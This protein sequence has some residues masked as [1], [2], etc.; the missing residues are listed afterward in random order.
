MVRCVA[1]AVFWIAIVPQA[2]D[3]TI[4]AEH[5]GTAQDFTDAF[6]D[7]LVNRALNHWSY[8]HQ[9]V[10]DTTLNKASTDRLGSEMNLA[11]APS[12]ARSQPMVR[13]QAL[14]ST[15]ATKAFG[16]FP[17]TSRSTVPAGS[18]IPTARSL[19]RQ[20]HQTVHALPVAELEKP[21]QEQTPQI[22]RLDLSDKTKSALAKSFASLPVKYHKDIEGF[23]QVTSKAFQ[24]ALSSEEVAAIQSIFSESGPASIHITNLP[25]SAEGKVLI[26]TPNDLM[27]VMKPVHK[28]DATSEAN[29]VGAAGLLGASVFT[30]SNFYGDDFVRNFPRKQGT[31][32]GWH[33][34]GVTAPP[35]RPPTQFFRDEPLIPELVVIFCLRGNKQAYTRVV[36]FARLVAATDK[37]DV[38]LLRTKPLVF[39]DTLYNNTMEPMYVV[40]GPEKEPVVELRPVERFEVRG[41]ANVIAAYRRIYDKAET[42]FSSVCLSS[43]EMLIVNNKRC[44]H[45]RSPYTAKDNSASDRWLQNVYASRRAELW[46]KHEQ[47][48]VTWPERRVP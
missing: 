34:D 17:H 37:K 38:E 36:D 39:H 14:A 29:L 21:T 45:A 7:K 2:C 12:A 35:F 24:A 43:G 3:A 9:D 33:R 41:D 19:Q 15:R 20:K 26:S 25:V 46:D 13:G 18:S 48:Y 44:S 42:L 16:Q 30:Y 32:L 40:K 31:D 10:E 8:N 6:I 11:L 47:S 5:A 22:A 27:E 23:E 28:E 4:A 1:F